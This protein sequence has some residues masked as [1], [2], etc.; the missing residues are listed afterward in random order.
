MRGASFQS[1]AGEVNEELPKESSRAYTAL[2]LSLWV[3]ELARAVGLS[4]S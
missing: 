2:E 1:D 3:L 4:S